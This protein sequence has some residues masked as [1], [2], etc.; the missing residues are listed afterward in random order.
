MKPRFVRFS[1]VHNPEQY[2]DD[3]IPWMHEAGNPFYDWLYG[4]PQATREILREMLLRRTSEMWIGRASLLLDGATAVGGFFATDGEALTRCVSADMVAL[5]RRMPAKERA[6]FTARTKA[7]LSVF[8]PVDADQYYL[9]SV[10]VRADCRG[11]GFGRRLVKEFLAQGRDAGFQRFRLNV[12]AD[13]Q[14]A[15]ELYRSF[16][17]EPVGQYMTA[18]DRQEYYIMAAELPT[19][20]S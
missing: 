8:P 17:F 5:L 12:S 16:G 13:N 9:S 18:E 19:E 2:V 14:P 7:A 6:D 11:R 10:G 1:E 15:V 20:R 3:V 4:G